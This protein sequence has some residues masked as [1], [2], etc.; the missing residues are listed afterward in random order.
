MASIGTVC[1]LAMA[2]VAVASEF[3]AP[4][5]TSMD[6]IK[7]EVMNSKVFQEHINQAEPVF[8]KGS[9]DEKNCRN[10]VGDAI[11]CLD[12]ADHDEKLKQMHVSG[13]QEEADHCKNI[14]K[15]MP[16]LSLLSMI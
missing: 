7:K 9:K 2:A 4:A 6:K 10:F 1:L 3:S 13:A 14:E 15:S 12:F 16:S 11:M 5:E 8:C